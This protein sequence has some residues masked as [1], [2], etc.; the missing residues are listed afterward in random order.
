[1]N[2]IELLSN[3]LE[4][5]KNTIYASFLLTLYFDE[6]ISKIN[7]I[8]GIKMEEEYEKPQI[9]N[10]YHNVQPRFGVQQA[11]YGPVNESSRSPPISLGKYS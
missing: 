4:K 1:M 2:T 8:Y 7:E 9:K 5:D 10:K 11:H 6:P 3:E